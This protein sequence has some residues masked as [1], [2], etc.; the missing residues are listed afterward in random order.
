MKKGETS[1]D[2]EYDTMAGRLFDKPL[3]K[4]REIK[5][6]SERVRGREHRKW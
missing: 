4:G 3:K 2:G 5:R 6:K 1:A